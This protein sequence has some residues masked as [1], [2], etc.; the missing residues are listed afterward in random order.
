MMARYNQ[1]LSPEAFGVALA[2]QLILMVFLGGRGSVWGAVIGSAVVYGIS[3]YFSDRGD[4]GD[5]IL[6]TVF[7][8]VLVVLPGGLASGVRVFRRTGGRFSREATT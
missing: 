2:L 8:A 4:Y 5:I 7:I 6:G 1:F 3:R